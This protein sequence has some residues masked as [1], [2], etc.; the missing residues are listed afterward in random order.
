MIES[1]HVKIFPQEQLRLFEILS[2]Q[3]WMNP[4]YLAG[5]T[6]LALQIG[7]RRSVDFDFFTIHDFNVRQI[8][9]TLSELGRFE[10]FNEENNTI[11]GALD[12]VKISFFKYVY[13]VIMPLKKHHCINLADTFD[14]AL[15]KLEAISGRGHK[16]D[17]FDLYFLFKK[18]PL[19][20]MLNNYE[21]KYG[22][23]VTNHYHLLKA[24]TYFDDAEK[25]EMPV[26][27]EEADWNKIKKTI[28]KAEQKLI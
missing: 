12:G 17:F 15:M 13:P 20:D 25:E 22:L 19:T 27:F 26:M 14:I 1:F 8:T 4:F 28:L 24:L 9:K 10:L 16:R 11:N 7:H 18:Y 6:A 3:E 2:E 23:A 5:G 21:K